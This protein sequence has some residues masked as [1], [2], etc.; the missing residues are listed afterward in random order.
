MAITRIAPDRTYD[1]AALPVQKRNSLGQIASS[2]VDLPVGAVFDRLTVVGDERRE[3][4]QY[5]V[6]CR[7]D[8]GL[9]IRTR[10]DGLKIGKK[11]QCGDHRRV[12]T[13][14][15]R[16][17]LGARNRTHGAS[18]S[19]EYNSWIGMKMRCSNPKDGRYEEYGGRGI[20]VFP[21][22]ESSFEAFL[23]YMG[24]RP[25]SAHSLDR[26]DNDGNYEPGNVRWADRVTQTQNRRPI[27][28]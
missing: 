28:R 11:K 16:E 14:A 23:A 6:L 21:E 18:R 2:H 10:V 3:G 1:N 4:K 7:C 26:I 20:S 15:Q 5:T 22:W 27:S 25:T 19:V 8:C 9:V 13:E 17:S 12:I 24:L